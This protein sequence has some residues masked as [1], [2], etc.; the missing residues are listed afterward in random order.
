[1]SGKLT[2]AS[3]RHRLILEAPVD[4]PDGAGGFERQWQ[5]VDEIYGRITEQPGPQQ[6]N[7]EKLENVSRVR[8]IIRWRP[9]MA[10]HV[11]LREGARIFHVRA[12]FDA[13]SKRRFMTCDCEEYSP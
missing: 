10:G 7:A 9:D 3:L 5:Q 6:L 13:D 1:M 4:V 11:R 8:I 2:I 12:T